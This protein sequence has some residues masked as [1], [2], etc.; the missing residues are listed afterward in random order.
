MKRYIR[1]SL[2]QAVISIT[3][4]FYFPLSSLSAEPPPPPGGEQRVWNETHL[5]PSASMQER[6]HR[7]NEFLDS[8]T[9]RLSS[10]LNE[11]KRMGHIDRRTKADIE[12]TIADV[13]RSMSGMEVTKQAGHL[14]A[15]QARTI[16]YDLGMAGDILAKQS[17]KIRASLAGVD[18]GGPSEGGGQRVSTEKRIEI[19]ATLAAM[20]RHLHETA[21]AIV[22]N[23][24]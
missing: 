10:R 17:E 4:V 12:S 3:A 7:T 14:D 16:A 13:Q 6:I 18:E 21:R 8:Q 23:L 5:V 2:F 24:K 1:G 20:G 9:P 19:A 22:R 11:L 15:R